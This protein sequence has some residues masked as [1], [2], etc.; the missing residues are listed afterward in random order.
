[1]TDQNLA[2]FQM[3]ANGY[4]FIDIADALKISDETV[5]ELDNYNRVHERELQYQSDFYA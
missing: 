3:R 1:M 5:Q 4:S 2:V